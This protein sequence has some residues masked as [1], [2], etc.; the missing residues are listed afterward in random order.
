MPVRAGD[1]GAREQCGGALRFHQEHSRPLPDKLLAFAEAKLEE[2]RAEPNSGPGKVI[3]CHWNGLTPGS[4][5]RP[6]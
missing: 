2:R 3:A 1:V 5:V 6:R 4:N